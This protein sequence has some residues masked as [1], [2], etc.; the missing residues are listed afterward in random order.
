M[1]GFN[2]RF[3]PIALRMKRFLKQVNGPFTMHYRVN[4]GPLPKDHWINDPEQGGGRIL[5]EVCHFVDFL[6]FIC[7]AAPHAV[8]ARSVQA[9]PS[10]Q[11]VAIT[12]EF[13]D[14]SLGTI[15]YVC[16][17]DRTF[18]K[19]RLEIFGG[20]CAAV[21]DDFRR[22][23]L[24]LHGRKQVFRSWL[25]Q[26]KGHAAEWTAFSECIRSGSPAPIRFKE[27]AA[28]TLATIRI[29]DSLR[30]GQEQQVIARAPHR[31][32]TPLVS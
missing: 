24:V 4:A 7:D 30:S 2:R 16:N 27:I 22:L 31:T 18:S 13:T 32:T 9:G 14:G 29:A 17:G 10:E 21:L 26:D 12:I 1:M 3:A 8:Q 23:E 20:G 6:S 19:E 25:K 28:T 5:G 11:N 15:S